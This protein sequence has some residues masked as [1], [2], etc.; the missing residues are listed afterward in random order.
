MDVSAKM[1]CVLFV[2]DLNALRPAF[3]KCPAPALLTV[4]SLGVT[5]EKAF[6]KLHDRAA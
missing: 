3:E 5:D 1:N 6:D 4:E 2:R